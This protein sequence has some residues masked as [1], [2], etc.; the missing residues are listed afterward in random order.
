MLPFGVELIYSSIIA[1]LEEK[2]IGHVKQPIFVDQFCIRLLSMQSRR[3][4][5]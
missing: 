1:Q 2:F 5:K 3:K 4:C